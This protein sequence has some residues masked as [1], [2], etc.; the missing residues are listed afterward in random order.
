M[1]AREA[2]AILGA[3]CACGALPG[4]P[5]ACQAGHCHLCRVYRCAHTGGITWPACASLTY[6]E[7][8][9]GMTTISMAVTP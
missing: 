6:E 9:N 3:D 2:E 1:M 7:P 4:V 5:C 8:F